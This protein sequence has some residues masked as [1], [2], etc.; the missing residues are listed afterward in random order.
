MVAMSADFASS[1]LPKA[2]VTGYGIRFGNFLKNFPPWNEKIDP[3]SWSS[4]TGT[5]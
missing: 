2:T 4:Q 5:T 1:G 3:Q